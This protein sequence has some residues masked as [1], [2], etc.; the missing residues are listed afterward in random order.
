MI[1]LNGNICCAVDVETTGFI[2]GFHCIWQIAIVPLDCNY[3]PQGVVPFY[4]DI[5]VKRPENIDKKAIKVC[6][7][8]FYKRQQRAIDPWTCADMFDTWFEKLKLPIYKKIQPLASNWVFDRAFIIDWL[9]PKTYEQLFH[10]Y[11]RDTQ[12]V[13]LHRNDVMA[14][15]GREIEFPKIGLSSLASRLGITNLKPHDAL[16]DALT[17]AEVYK[18]LVTTY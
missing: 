4:M 7:V 17:S 13:A 11:Y 9:G 14:H 6:N 2:P 15:Q 1:H 5:R 8:D 3:S 10:P 12:V 16:Q 18:R